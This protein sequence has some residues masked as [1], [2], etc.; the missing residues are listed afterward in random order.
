MMLLGS[1]S[2][3]FWHK[4]VWLPPNFTWAQLEPKYEYQ[5]TDYRHLY[6]YPITLAFVVLFI[7]HLTEK[8]VSLDLTD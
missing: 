2:D 1:F 6:L 3:I 8:R 7:R 4:S 5:F